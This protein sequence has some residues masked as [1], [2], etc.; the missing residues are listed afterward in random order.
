MGFYVVFVA[1]GRST[2]SKIVLVL[3][4]AIIPTFGICLLII[5]S[6]QRRLNRKQLSTS[7]SQLTDEERILVEKS[8]SSQCKLPL[9]VDLW[10]DNTFFV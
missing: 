5:C 6:L 1:P 7:G 2:R 3:L 4:I 9:Y 10:K 8:D